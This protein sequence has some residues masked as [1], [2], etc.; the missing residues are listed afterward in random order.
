MNDIR[1]LAQDWD[2][3]PEPL[4][5]AV[6][7]AQR[8]RRHWEANHRMMADAEPAQAEH[9]LMQAHKAVA[10]LPVRAQAHLHWKLAE[11]LAYGPCSL[12]REQR[13]QLMENVDLVAEILAALAEPLDTEREDPQQQLKWFILAWQEAGGQLWEGGRYDLDLIDF[14]RFAYRHLGEP[15]SE[16]AVRCR[17]NR[18]SARTPGI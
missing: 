10:A 16:D 12:S 7:A 6:E 11:R 5:Q 4:I 13:R 3:D 2:V 8:R 15:L 9:R 17:L 14:L 1:E 18:I